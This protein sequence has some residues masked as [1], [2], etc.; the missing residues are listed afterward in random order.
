MEVQQRGEKG[1]MVEGDEKKGKRKDKRKT[2]G[3]EG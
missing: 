1:R 3:M 2:D